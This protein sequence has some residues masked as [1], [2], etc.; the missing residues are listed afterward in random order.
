MGVSINAAVSG[1]FQL[2]FWLAIITA[3]LCIIARLQH[4]QLDKKLQSDSE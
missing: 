1:E 4:K 3:A 2:P